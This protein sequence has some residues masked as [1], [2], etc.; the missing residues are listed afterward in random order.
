MTVIK[1]IMNTFVLTSKTRDSTVLSQRGKI[2]ISTRQNF[3]SVA[4]M[5]NIKNNRIFRTVKDPV[6]SNCKFNNTE[7]ACEM[8]AVFGNGFDYFASDFLT[9][10]R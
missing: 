6:Q 9:K 7:I 2:F 8:T 10:N 5:A 1:K 4:L 3:V